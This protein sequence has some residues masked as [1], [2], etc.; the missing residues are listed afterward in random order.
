LIREADRRVAAAAVATVMSIVGVVSGSST[1]AQAAGTSSPA[2]E[3][4]AA[5]AAV[6]L[7]APAVVG[8]QVEVAAQVGHATVDG[9]FEVSVSMS[10]AVTAVNGDG[11]YTTRTT[12]GTV[13]VHVGAE[14]AG[15]GVNALGTRSFEQSFTPTGAANPEASTLIDAASMTAEQ[16][17]S[18]RALVDAMSMISVG[19]PAEPVAVGAAWTSQGTMG[20]NGTIIPVTYQC[21]LT[22]LDASTYTMEVSYT[23]S[24]SQPSDTG[25]IEATMAGW[26]TITGSVAN[27]LV[28]SAKLNQA[29]DGIKGYAPFHHDTSIS[30]DATAVTS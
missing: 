2:T 7:P 6:Q 23:E 15:D 11:S 9:R 8:Q 29:I 27:P 1:P 4:A 16:Q 17:E 19:F 14:L 26:G 10:T 13:D 25:T 21:R 20:S 3:A 30:V 22:A 18:G 28:I 24:F 12:I 5:A